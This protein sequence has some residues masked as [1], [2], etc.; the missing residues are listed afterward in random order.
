MRRAPMLVLVPILS[1]VLWVV[2]CSTRPTDQIERTESARKQAVEA[3]AEF[4]APTEWQAA[5]QAYQESKAAVDK[6]DWG[7][8]ASL[9]LRAESRFRKARDIGKGKRDFAVKEIADLKSTAEKRCATL[10]ENIDKN[11]AK[12]GSKKGEFEEICKAV[13]EKIAKVGLQL[14]G[15]HYGDAKVS[16]GTALRDIWEGEKKLDEALGG[17]KKK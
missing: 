10:K 16:A 5:D 3:E 15:K 14:E 11:S 1:L 6:Q 4:F 2:A 9:L 13:D 17:G 8:S 7:A 12:L